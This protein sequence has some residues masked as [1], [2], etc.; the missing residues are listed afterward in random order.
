MFSVKYVSLSSNITVYVN[1]IFFSHVQDEEYQ[2]ENLKIQCHK[3][4][5]SVQQEGK[6]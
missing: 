4:G 2:W 6:L 1:P 3:N 5:F